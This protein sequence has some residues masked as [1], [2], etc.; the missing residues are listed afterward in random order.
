MKELHAKCELISIVVA[1]F[2]VGFIIWH[3]FQIV[4]HETFFIAEPNKLILYSEIAIGFLLIA[5]VIVHLILYIKNW[6][7]K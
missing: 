3:L 2:S 5:C 7:G 6:G 4:I 1:L